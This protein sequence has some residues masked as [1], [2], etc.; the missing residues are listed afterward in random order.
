M[1][2]DITTVPKDPAKVA[3]I[4]ASAM[5]NFAIYGYRA[6]KTDV[7][8][9]E[10]AVSKG[11]VFRYFGNKAHLFVAALQQA[12][13][14]ME[15]VADYS[16]WREANDLVDMIVRATKY[17]IALELQYPD[18]FGVL[19]NGY[20]S[21]DQAPAEV[22]AAIKGIYQSATK[23]NLARLVTPVLDRLPLRPEIDQQ[24]IMIMMNAVMG[25]IEKETKLFMKKNPQAT[26]NEFDEIIAHAKKYI[27]VV[28]HGILS[29]RA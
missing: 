8:A 5:H 3:R 7:I 24:T 18:E 2:E 10:A 25:Q 4:L 9:H 27:G 29:E 6:T 26:L 16:I 14:K 12:V 20:V 28:E 19:M 15:A 1:T 13:D 11:I 23:N 17:K 22:Q 21:A